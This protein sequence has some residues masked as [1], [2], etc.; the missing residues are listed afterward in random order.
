MIRISKTDP[1]KESEGVWT[2]Y[3]GTK[4]LIARTHNTRF[5]RAMRRKAEDS[6]EGSLTALSDE[7]SDEVMIE[8]MA[9]TILLDWEPFVYDGQEV[10]YSKENALSLLKYD[11]DF[12]DYVSD[13]SRNPGN[14]R[15]TQESD[16]K[17]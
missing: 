11:I 10:K 17:K 16:V 3:E 6:V 9:E 4:V 13:F 7:R 15:M 14:Y 2:T 12:R 5:L 8:V 1:K